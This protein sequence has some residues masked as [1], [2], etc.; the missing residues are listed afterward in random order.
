MIWD[1]TENSNRFRQLIELTAAALTNEADLLLWPEAAVPNLIRY[2][3]A[4]H[5]AV[6]SLARSNGLWMIIGS[7]DASLR[8]GGTGEDDVDYF[9]ASFLINPRGEIAASFRLNFLVAFGEYIPLARWLPF[10]KWFTP[11]TGGFTPGTKPIPFELER[12]IPNQPQPGDVSPPAG[13]E[14]D[15]PIKTAT[16][17]CFE[18]VF[19]HLVRRYVDADTDFLVNLTNDGWFG[20]GSAQWQHAASAVFRAIENGVPLLRCCN[21]GLTCWVDARGRVREVFRDSGGS[22][23]GAGFVT[24]QIPLHAPDK[25]PPRTFYNRHGDWFGWGCVAVTGAALIRPFPL[26]KRRG[27]N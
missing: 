6:T 23:Y 27:L 26:F 4:T 10:L 24:W 1:T 14:A 8:P 12:R 17:I 15:A 2:D 13:P 18:D 16:L 3:E 9:N 20:E 5:Q 25:R 7:D 19:P 22:I 11:I 21:N